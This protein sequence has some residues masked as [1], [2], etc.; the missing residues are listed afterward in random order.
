MDFKGKK[1]AVIGAG[2]EGISTADHLASKGAV[3]SLLDKKTES[4]FGT[5]KINQIKKLPVKLKFGDDYLND[6]EAFDLIFRSPGVRRD[7]PEIINAEKAGTQITSQIKL[8][9]DLCSAPIVGITGTKGKGT[10]S[11]LIYEILKAAGKNMSVL[12]IAN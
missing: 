3:V 11:S 2:V 8:F 12:W 1:V 9:F 5:E 4:E 10:T 7:L 6:L